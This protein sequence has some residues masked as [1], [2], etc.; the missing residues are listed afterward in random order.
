MPIDHTAISVPKDKIDDV[1]GFYLKVLEP[2]GYKKIMEFPGV[3]GLGAPKPDFWLS[4][5]G[6]NEAVPPLHFALTADGR[7]VVKLFHEA[8]VGAGAKCNGP[9]GIREHYGPNYYAAFVIDPLGNN[10]E[11]VCHKPGA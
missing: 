2:L 11:V 8:A 10:L 1:L 7:E 6:V 5:I 9:P 3:Y 4:S